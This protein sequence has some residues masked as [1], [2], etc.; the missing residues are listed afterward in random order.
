MTNLLI[1]H[2]LEIIYVSNL[3]LLEKEDLMQYGT[4]F[5][6]TQFSCLK[7]KEPLMFTSSCAAE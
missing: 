3:D 1:F 5:V 4:A 2:R 7:M 6:L